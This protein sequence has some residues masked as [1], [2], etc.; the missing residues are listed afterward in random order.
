MKKLYYDFH[1]HSCLSPCADNDMTPYDIAGLAKLNG[2][3]IVALTDHNTCLNVPAFISA[4][5]H[6]DIMPVAGM[7]L[8]T[9][10]EIHLVCLFPNSINALEFS[11]FI[12]T[13]LLKIKNK[14]DVFGNQLIFYDENTV[15]ESDLLYSSAAAISIDEAFYCINDIGG[16]CYPAHIER[17]SNGIISILGA[18]PDEPCFSYYEMQNENQRILEKFPSLTKL[19]RLY[20]SDSHN[21]SKIIKQEAF[22]EFVYS[23]IKRLII[24]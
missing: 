15:V 2:L 9:E 4:C 18:F 24:I 22:S 11:S 19:Q 3:D 17:S 10:E 7:E 6:Y 16:I 1:I 12:E 5:Q 14:P 21:L 8:T 20:G 13:K 23:Q